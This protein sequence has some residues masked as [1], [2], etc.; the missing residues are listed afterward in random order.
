M[1]G[2]ITFSEYMA[3]FTFDRYG[4][5]SPARSWMKRERCENCKYWE[6]LPIAEQP[7]AGWGVMGQCNCIHEPKMMKSG[8]WKVG[9]TSYC[10]DFE[11][12]YEG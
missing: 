4:K 10:N 11:R 5:K 12:K 8:Y 6:L 9:K 1:E 7:P 3:D 2:Q